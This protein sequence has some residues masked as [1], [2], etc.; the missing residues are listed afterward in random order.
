MERRFPM[1]I[2][3]WMVSSGLAAIALLLSGTIQLIGQ[4]AAQPAPT[5]AQLAQQAAAERDH[6]NLLQIRLL[7][8]CLLQSFIMQFPLRTGPISLSATVASFSSAMAA[9]IMGLLP[10]VRK[11]FFFASSDRFSDTARTS[12]TP[13][14]AENK[15]CPRSPLASQ[16][17]FPPLISST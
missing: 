8:A 9:L 16:R 3:R 13:D 14:P 2:S 17:A 5:P 1:L 7:I 6:Q 15:I 11:Y 12:A 4:A 10:A